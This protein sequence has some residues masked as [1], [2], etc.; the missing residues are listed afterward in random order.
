MEVTNEVEQ[1]FLALCR[2]DRVAE[3][4]RKSDE[5]MPRLYDD[6][7]ESMLKKGYALPS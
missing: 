7:K 4:L 2:R 6:A 3:E 5:E 1:Y